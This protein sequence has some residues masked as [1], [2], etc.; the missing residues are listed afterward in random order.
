MLFSTQVTSVSDKERLLQALDRALGS[1]MT[2]APYL[3]FFRAAE[4]ILRWCRQRK[5]HTT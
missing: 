1:W 3:D 5:S 2:Y 4:A